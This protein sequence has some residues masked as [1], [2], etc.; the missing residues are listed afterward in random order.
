MISKL[1]QKIGREEHEEA[2]RHEVEIKVINV[3]L[4]MSRLFKH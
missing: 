3:G 1:F 2:L 4:V